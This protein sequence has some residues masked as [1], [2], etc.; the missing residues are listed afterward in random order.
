MAVCTFIGH[1]DC[2]DKIKSKLRKTIEELIVNENVDTFYVG[3]HGGFDYFVYETLCDLEAKYNIG[4]NV[5]L[6]YLDVKQTY[7]DSRKTVF[8]TI[9]ETTPKRYAI[10]KRNYY[11]I[12]NQSIL[13]VMSIIHF[14]M[15]TDF[16]K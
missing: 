6:A 12:K 7:Y 2:P 13:F 4:I 10:T 9:L 5:V 15:H 11:M 1:K 8:P 16:L 3:T 14:R